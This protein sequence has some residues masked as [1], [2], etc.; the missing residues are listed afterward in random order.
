MLGLS[1]FVTTQPGLLHKFKT[2]CDGIFICR[3]ETSRGAGGIF[4]DNL[5]SGDWYS[6]FVFTQDVGRGSAYPW[7]L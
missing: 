7:I 4:Y 2:W 6:D 1:W 3:T 5:D